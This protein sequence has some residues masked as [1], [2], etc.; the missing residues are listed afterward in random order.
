MS[1]NRYPLSPAGSHRDLGSANRRSPPAAPCP[2]ANSAPRAA[3][4]RIQRA[5]SSPARY[6]SA[7]APVQYRCALTASAVSGARLAS[8]RCPQ[9]ACRSVQPSPPNSG[10]SATFR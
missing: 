7:A 9:A 10:G 6:A 2:A 5:E 8:R 4:S 1:R 3:S